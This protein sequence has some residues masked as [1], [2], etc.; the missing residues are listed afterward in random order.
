MTQ[1]TAQ[2]NVMTSMPFG[3]HFHPEE[4]FQLDQPIRPNHNNPISNPTGNNLMPSLATSRSPSTLLDL[5]S[6]TIQKN[7][8][9]SLNKLLISDI[10]Y[11]SC[12]DTSS[13]TST[14]SIFEESFYMHQ[15]YYNADENSYHFG[16]YEMGKDTNGSIYIQN[17]FF[18][19]CENI[20][21][22]NN[23]HELLN[24]NPYNYYNSNKLS[25]TNYE[26]V[27]GMQYNIVGGGNNVSICTSWNN[28]QDTVD[29]IQCGSIVDSEM[30]VYNSQQLE[31]VD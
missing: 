17:Q 12:D 14:S 11:E 28:P 26:I 25:A 9:N 21:E 27:N 3:D 5:E 30:S 7:H 18:D 20:A 10:K 8:S 15:P 23:R 22:T 13:L 6:G 16:A 29:L 1:S 4:I 2:S 24:S 19:H 31:Y